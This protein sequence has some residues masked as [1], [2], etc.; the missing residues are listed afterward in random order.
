MICAED[1]IGFGS[2]HDGIMVLDNDARVGMP[3]SEY[4]NLGND[5][6]LEVD[7]TP[8]RVDAASYIGVARDLAAY[9]KQKQPIGYQKPDVSA[10]KVDNNKLPIAVDVANP[11]ACP[12]YSGLTIS[13]ITVTESPEWLQ[14]RLKAMGLNPINN[15]VDITNYVLFETGQPLP[16]QFDADGSER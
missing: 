1:E 4:F 8:N 7:L 13:G 9:L 10:F 2:N 5:Y 3:A 12:R 16:M 14:K 15:V 6:V 11:E